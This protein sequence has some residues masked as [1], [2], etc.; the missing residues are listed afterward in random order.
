MNNIEFAGTGVQVS[1]MCL[2]TMMFGDRCDEAESARILETAVSQGTTFIDTAAAYCGGV[3]EEILGRIIKGK[4][5][6]LFIG[7]KVTK[8]TNADWIAQSLD[9]SLARLQTDYVD[10]FMIHWPRENMLIEPMMETL[11]NA[12]K[13]GKARYIGC[14]NFP[15]WLFAHCNAAAERNGWAKF[16]NNQIPYNLIERGVEVEVIPQAAAENIA[17]T[18]YRSLCLGLLAGKYQ[19]GQSIPTDS[20]GQS[21]KRIAAWLEKYGNA[22]SGFHAFAAEHNLHPAQLAVAWVRHSPGVAAPIVGVS[23]E[24][25]LQASIDAFDVVLSDAEY[26]ALTGLFDTVVK[27][28][29]GGNFANL[30]R[31]TT[32]VK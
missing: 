3:T 22:I 31:M 28:E 32:L 18:T 26:E 16:V 2:G 24:R 1:E 14:C 13:A 10:L 27:E 20:R 5:N 9:E 30:R 4:R 15:A 17:I 7:T 11:N 29:S 12:V 23:S 21:D 6:E 8:N 19:P 25:Q